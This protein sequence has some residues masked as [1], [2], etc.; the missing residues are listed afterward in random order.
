M[1]RGLFLLILSLLT[2]Q[3]SAQDEVK[4]RPSQRLVAIGDIHADPEALAIILQGMGLVDKDLRWIAGDT[5]VVFTGD[6]VSKGT[7]TRTALDVVMRLQAEAKIVGGGVHS[8]LGNHEYY[9][10]A[11]ILEDV[12]DDDWT[13]FSDFR[14]KPNGS[15]QK[16]YRRAFRKNSPYAVWVRKL[17]AILKVNDILFVHGGLTKKMLGWSYHEI[18]ST[19]SAEV[20]YVQGMGDAPARTIDW[21][22][23]EIGPFRTRSF[24]PEKRYKD[25]PRM[26][27]EE[28]DVLLKNWNVSQVLVG[29]NVIDPEIMLNH[30]IYG[31]RVI[32]IDTGNTQ[33]MDNGQITAVDIV[34]EIL[35]SYRFKRKSGE[36]KRIESR[37]LRKSTCDMLL[38]SRA[39]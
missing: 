10:A 3:A 23:P 26:S 8:I 28:L 1:I 27:P 7:D 39:S 11:G 6:L 12:H 38:R 15:L 2:W 19:L 33:V 5:H 30:P 9:L 31:D 4:L 35:T 34:D 36:R 13:S 16:A 20:S 22:D 32:M 14:K 37:S 18:N 17:P 24:S 21:R 29:H 25:Y